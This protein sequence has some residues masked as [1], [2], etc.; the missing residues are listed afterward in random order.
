MSLFGNFAARVGGFL[1]RDASRSVSAV[2]ESF[3]HAIILFG[4]FKLHLSSINEI[5]ISDFILNGLKGRVGRLDTLYGHLHN[6]HELR[7]SINLGGA[8]KIIELA[9]KEIKGL[10]IRDF[11]ARTQNIDLDKLE[12]SDKLRFVDARKALI[13]L[14]GTLED[15]YKDIS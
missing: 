4:A 13:E 11:I 14:Q 6:I 9:Q 1:Q 5:R 8:Q 10:Y 7:S 3:N 12:I 15:L 2:E